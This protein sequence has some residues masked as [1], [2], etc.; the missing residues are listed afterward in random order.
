MKCIVTTCKN[1]HHAKGYCFNHYDHLRRFGDLIPRRKSN[2][3]GTITQ[4]GYKMFNINKK[5]ISEQRLVMQKFLGRI[6]KSNEIVHHVNGNKLDNRIGN[7]VIT[8]RTEHA[9]HHHATDR[10]RQKQWEKIMAIGHKRNIKIQKPRPR[11]M[12]EGLIWSHH[13]LRKSWI[14]RKCKVC[15]KIFWAR[16]D[17]KS[18]GFCKSCSCQN[19]NHI[20]LNRIWLKKA[21]S[22]LPIPHFFSFL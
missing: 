1:T 18:K 19:A 11:K 9:R 21:P 6:L 3:Q 5:M 12:V 15:L 20:R 2:G 7:L 14:V 22:R 4:E 10:S 17:H 13:K 16:K 8:S